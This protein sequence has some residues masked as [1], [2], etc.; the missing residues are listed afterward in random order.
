MGMGLVPFT[1]FVEAAKSHPIIGHGMVPYQKSQ[2]K[3]MAHGA[4]AHSAMYQHNAWCQLNVNKVQFIMEALA[5]N[6]N[7]CLNVNNTV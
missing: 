2:L 3:S 6:C 4:L 5:N 7:L 1:A